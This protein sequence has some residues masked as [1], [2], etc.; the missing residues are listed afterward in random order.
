MRQLSSEVSIRRIK[1]SKK[2]LTTYSTI[3]LSSTL[4]TISSAMREII[5]DR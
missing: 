3:K 4:T 2:S 1:S 5:S